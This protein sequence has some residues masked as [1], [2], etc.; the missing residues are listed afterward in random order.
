MQSFS[1]CFSSLTSEAFY[2]RDMRRSMR[3]KWKGRRWWKRRVIFHN[4]MFGLL[5]PCSQFS[6]FCGIITF[7][8]KATTKMIQHTIPKIYIYIYFVQNVWQS[9]LL[10]ILGHKKAHKI[11]IYMTHLFCLRP[12]HNIMFLCYLPTKFLN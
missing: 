10:S 12:K 9:F 8:F 2:F 7:I 5:F 1:L 6:H 11:F 4:T 3:K